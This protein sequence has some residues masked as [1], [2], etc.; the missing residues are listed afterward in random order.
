[1]DDVARFR[2]EDPDQLV[3]A[4]FACPLCLHEAS[5]V[6]LPRGDDDPVAQCACLP[7]HAGW[8]VALSPT[9]ML[10][11]ALAPPAGLVS[12]PM[13]GVGST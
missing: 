9:Q 11:L 4:S 13:W 8:E 2:P 12:P 3:R 7:C 5:M 6:R 1:M 10:R